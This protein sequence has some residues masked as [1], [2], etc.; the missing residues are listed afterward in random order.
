MSFC[1]P[2]FHRSNFATSLP[3]AKKQ[4]SNKSPTNEW[5]LAHWPFPVCKCPS[6]S[7]AT[8]LEKQYVSEITTCFIK[9]L[10]KSVWHPKTHVKNPAI[11]LLTF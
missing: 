10:E 5:M 2:E 11:Y 6:T 3:V 1:L 7:L 9:K 8:H 4:Q